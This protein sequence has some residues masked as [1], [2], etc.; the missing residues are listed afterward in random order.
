VILMVVA[1]RIVS[2][3]L[4]QSDSYARA[5]PDEQRKRQ[6][7]SIVRVVLHFGSSIG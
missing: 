6:F 1:V 2:M 5:H 3:R 4:R 7:E